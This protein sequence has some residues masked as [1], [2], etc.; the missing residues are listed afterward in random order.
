MDRGITLLAHQ[1]KHNLKNS[2]EPQTSFSLLGSNATKV[3][4]FLLFLLP[5]INNKSPRG[6]ISTP[7]AFSPLSLKFMLL[8]LKILDNGVRIFVWQSETSLRQVTLKQKQQQQ[9]QIKAHRKLVLPGLSSLQ[10][11]GYKKKS[12]TGCRVE[13]V[14]E[15]SYHTNVENPCRMSAGDHEL[16]QAVLVL[17]HPQEECIPPLPNVQSGTGTYQEGNQLS[18]EVNNTATKTATL[19]LKKNSLLMPNVT[20]QH[21]QVTVPLKYTPFKF[22]K[23]FSMSLGRRAK[24]SG[25]LIFSIRLLT[26]L[27][28]NLFSVCL[29][30]FLANNRYKK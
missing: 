25:G 27:T 10:C 7:T 30:I 24:K 1:C 6:I 20:S 15:F 3:I 5:T 4:D 18:M 28:C 16:L 26:S 19:K 2:S 29:T 21:Q 11:N 23:C 17:F 9:Q 13:T 12:G 8:L 22:L 14:I